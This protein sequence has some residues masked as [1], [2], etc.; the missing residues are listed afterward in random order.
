MDMNVDSLD[1]LC[2]AQIALTLSS[3]NMFECALPVVL[4]LN[5]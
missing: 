3:F 5:T 1:V 2:L 4:G